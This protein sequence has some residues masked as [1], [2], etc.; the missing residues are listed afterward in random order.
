MSVI[1]IVKSVVHCGSTFVY[2]TV[3]YYYVITL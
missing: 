2:R 1:N 3:I